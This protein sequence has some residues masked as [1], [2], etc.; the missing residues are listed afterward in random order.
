MPV[1]SDPTCRSCGNPLPTGPD[2][3]VAQRTIR[4][5]ATVCDSC[6]DMDEARRKAD[7]QTARI[8]QYTAICPAIYQNTNPRDPRLDQ[9]LLAKV[10]AWQYG[11]KG[12]VLFGPTRKGKTR[13][14]WLLLRRLW[15][16]ERIKFIAM[17][18]GEFARG[19]GEMYGLSGEAGREW[20]NRLVYA[21]VLFIDDFGKEKAT[22]RVEAEL[23]DVMEHRTSNGRPMLLTTN[24]VG[25]TLCAK[26]TA[27]RG[28]PIIE[29]IREF[30][31]GVNFGI[32]Q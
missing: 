18:S 9:A 10:M 14:M 22:E 30:C 21:P 23:F 20:F 29:R 31:A 19:C 28:E 32:R 24:G 25:D 4:L 3:E 11:P 16:E 8:Q 1:T 2:V 7:A 13:M 6:A 12:L 17:T 26:F 5:Q 15:V 27:D